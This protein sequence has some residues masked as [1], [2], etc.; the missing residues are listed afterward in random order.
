MSKP[1]ARYEQVEVESRASLRKWLFANHLR[2]TG[3]WLVTR[4][5]SAGGGVK[6]NDIVEEALCFGWVDSVPRKLD[7]ERSMLLLTPR[8]S[9]SKW[10][11]KNK[12][13]VADLEAQ[14]LMHASGQAIV[15]EAKQRGT[16]AA[17]DHVS[18]LVVPEDLQHALAKFENARRFWNDFPPSTRRGI[19]EWI[20]NA[21]LAS[22]RQ[23]RVQATAELAERNIRANQWPRP[24]P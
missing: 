17:L 8:K 10:S 14:G 9:T 6:Y 4:K 19:L 16:W 15:E 2:K 3:I 13:H 11:A 20:D 22:T 12:A 7:A 5:R 23:K 1:A 21:K 24:P 18:Q